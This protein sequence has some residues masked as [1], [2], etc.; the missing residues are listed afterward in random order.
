[1]SMSRKKNALRNALHYLPNLNAIIFLFITCFE[2]SKRYGCTNVSFAIPLWTPKANKECPTILS[3]KCLS[4]QTK[5]LPSSKFNLFFKPCIILNFCPF[6]TIFIVMGVYNT[7]GFKTETMYDYYIA[8]KS[9]FLVVKL[10]SHH[11][12][13]YASLTF[14]YHDLHT[15]YTKTIQDQKPFQNQNFNS[16]K[17]CIHTITLYKW[18]CF[19]RSQTSP[20]ILTKMKLIKK[21]PKTYPPQ[22]SPNNQKETKSHGSPCD[23]TINHKKTTSHDAHNIS[24]CTMTKWWNPTPNLPH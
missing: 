14:S 20:Y 7:N 13:G 8:M 5:H 16:H 2:W 17:F 3:S 12:I 1:M 18:R 15:N 9:M 11:S 22:G 24:Q 23:F 21:L 6:W 4:Y 10:S 19:S